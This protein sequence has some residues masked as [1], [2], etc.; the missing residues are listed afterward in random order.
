[1]AVAIADWRWVAYRRQQKISALIAD[2][3]QV[4]QGGLP[5][6][7]PQFFEPLGRHAVSP[8]R[9]VLQA[10]EA[11]QLAKQQALEALGLLKD[12]S[13]FPLLKEWTQAQEPVLKEAAI[14]ALGTLQTPE[15]ISYLLTL[16]DDPATQQAAIV[17]LGKAR[18][19]AARERLLR[20]VRDFEP[21][22]EAPEEQR[23]A[24]VAT[25]C[26][27]AEALGRIGGNGVQEA[28]LPLLE[29]PQIRWWAAAGL[30]WLNEQ[31][32]FDILIE[33]FMEGEETP[34]SQRTVEVLLDIGEP[35]HPYLVRAL[36]GELS[37][38]VRANLMALVGHLQLG[39]A[40]E[41]LVRILNDEHQ[42]LSLRQKAAET[43]GEIGCA[44]AFKALLAAAAEAPA[45]LR[46][47]IEFGLVKVQAAEANRV[48]L[49]TLKSSQTSERRLAARLLGLRGVEEAVPALTEA[50][51]D[52]DAETRR[53]AVQ[54]LGVIGDPSAIPAVEKLLNDPD[55]E[56]RRKAEATAA[57][58]QALQS[59]P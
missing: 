12:P 17:A 13:V 11:N 46:R 31:Q 14:T 45:P 20:I 7:S 40:V 51:A 58:L 36:S 44:E 6:V 50:L 29:Q 28:L 52:E 25:V 15:A 43:L 55:P 37:P 10:P 30:A 18:V 22:V 4:G 24:N 49:E 1:V 21:E 48:L 56:V 19:P 26:A 5:L 27:A 2:L 59:Q 41:P 9:E 39:E 47:S 54:A 23:A 8:L 38:A 3:G 32:G 57:L 53:N 34:E 35:A 42:P 16:L 33:E